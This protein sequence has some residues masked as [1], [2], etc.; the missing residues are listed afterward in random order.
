MCYNLNVGDRMYNE[1]KKD[2]SKMS[3]EE[4]K[5][6]YST[7]RDLIAKVSEKIEAICNEENVSSVYKYNDLNEVE[8]VDAKDFQ[9]DE[10]LYEMQEIVRNL[11]EELHEIEENY[12]G[13]DLEDTPILES[14][15]DLDNDNYS[16]LG[17]DNPVHGRKI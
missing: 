6:Q 8:L 11:E 7:I 5:Q 13:F 9:K 14:G 1:G 2:Y 10:V 15:I 4:L 16:E 3:E 17:V 12:D